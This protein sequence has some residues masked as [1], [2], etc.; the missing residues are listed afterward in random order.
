MKISQLKVKAYKFYGF[1]YLELIIYMGIVTI[2]MAALIPFAWNTIEGGVKSATQ[3][4]I[5]SQARFVSERLK[6][7][8]RNATDIY[9]VS[10][11]Q[12]SLATANP[13][14]NPTIFALNSGNI[15][16]S[17]GITCP[18][19]LNSRNTTISSL[20]F[21]NYS[22]ADNNTKNVQFA[23]T[24][25]ANYP[26]SGSRQEYNGSTT[27]EGS[28]EVRSSQPWYDTNYLYKKLIMIDHTKVSGGANLSNFPVLISFTDPDLKT[29]GNGGKVQSSNGFDIVAIDGMQTTRLDYEIEKYDP[30]T[31]K[32]VMWVRI[33]TL[34]YC[35]DSVFYL[36][37]DNT[38]ISSS[39]ENIH[40]V[41]DANYH[42]V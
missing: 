26:G 32:I 7:E 17:Q 22:S 34:S 13:V 1:T 18:V 27:L 2:V 14:T 36:Y 37:F 28:G 16:I 3:Q 5:S 12:L 25:G 6:Y 39:Q 20:A 24:V 41:W 31:G 10:A 11:T 9:S 38:T 8:I 21:T 4:E 33:P 40:G 29:T 15:T 19:A 42:A 30:T 35:T 23:L